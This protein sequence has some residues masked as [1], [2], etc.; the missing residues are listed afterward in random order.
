MKENKLKLLKI[1]LPIAI[2]ILFVGSVCL[3]I[4]S[5]GELSQVAEP[6]IVK[7]LIRMNQSKYATKY[8][9][10]DTFSFDK[11]AAVI[12]LVA[13]DPL[14]DG[15]V[16]IDRLPSSEFGFL[17]NGT[18]EYFSNPADIHMTMDVESISVVSRVYRNL[19]I[20]LPVKV[21]APVDADKLV[22]ELLFE[23]EH[24]NIYQDGKLLTYED[25]STKPA[26]DKP[27]LSNEGTAPQDGSK[28]SGGV[29]LRNFQ[30]LNMKVEFEIVCNE[31]AE[32]EFEIL[33]CMRNKD[34]RFP[35]SF[36]LTVNGERIP[37]LDAMTIP[38]DPAG[39]YFAPYVTQKVTI[40]LNR[41][42]NAITFD[43]GSAAGTGSPCNLDAIR[44]KAASAI[45]AAYASNTEQE[46]VA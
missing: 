6:E 26:T 4:F 8:F 24:A 46:E 22:S 43:S 25:L 44:L 23:A 17:V 27:F 13:K 16:K 32:V 45:L 9:V 19:G 41:G 39:G 29:C 21:V 12:Q 15:I 10:G 38:A 37:A 5:G 42:F 35:D 34:V 18:G 36:V 28:L 40:K 1:L 33:L 30:S 2:A 20:E 11:E 14:I 3:A 31:E 7:G